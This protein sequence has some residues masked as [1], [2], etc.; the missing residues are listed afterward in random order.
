[1][2]AKHLERMT[3]YNETGSLWGMNNQKPWDE[4]NIVQKIYLFFLSFVNIEH[5]ESEKHHGK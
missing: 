1:M 2:P 3:E 4:I 5:W